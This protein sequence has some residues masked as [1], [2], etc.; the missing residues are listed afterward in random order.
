[1]IESEEKWYARCDI[2]D[3]FETTESVDFR[4]EV[5]DQAEREG[6]VVDRRGVGALCPKHVAYGEES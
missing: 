3:C 5:A 1:M 6:W 4:D 2:R